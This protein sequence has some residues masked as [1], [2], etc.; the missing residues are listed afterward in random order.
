MDATNEMNASNGMDTEAGDTPQPVYNS[1][2][3]KAFKWKICLSSAIQIFAGLVFCVWAIINSENENKVD[4]GAYTHCFVVLAGILG[5][6]S[7]IMQTYESALFHL[8]STMVG[9]SI[10]CWAWTL[11]TTSDKEVCT[12][13]YSESLCPFIRAMCAV[14][15]LCDPL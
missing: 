6:H 5:A 4:A 10:T 8:V 2:A 7:A 3:A 9:G 13:L 14:D 1:T 15:N 12:R 11:G